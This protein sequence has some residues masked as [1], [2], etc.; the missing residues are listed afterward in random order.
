MMQ[1]VDPKEPL[2]PCPFCGGDAA[3]D[4]VTTAFENKPRFRAYCLNPA[5]RVSMDW[6]W[7]SEEDAV[8]AWNRRAE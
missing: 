4:T 1:I 8:R 2:L 7:W 6:D 5:C 3:M